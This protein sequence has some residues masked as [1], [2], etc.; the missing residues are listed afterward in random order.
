MESA[1]R[2]AVGL[3]RRVTVGT[4]VSLGGVVLANSA[5]IVVAGGLARLLSVDD[6]GAFL[7]ANS[8]TTVLAVIGR[9][10]LGQTV[11]RRIAA[12]LALQRP[13]EARSAAVRVAGLT[14]LFA[15]VIGVIVASPL[16]RWGARELVDTP[17]LAGATL[18][19]ALW[20]VVDTVRLNL[21]EIE[22]GYGRMVAATIA[23]QA[24]RY[25]LMAA[26]V[27]VLLASRDHLTLRSACWAMAG[28]G[29][30]VL[31]WVTVDA[32]RALGRRSLDTN[33]PTRGI[34]RDGSLVMFWEL[35]G[36]L[37]TQIDV[38]VVSATLGGVAIARYGAA[39]RVAVLLALP[40][41]AI[42]L[43][44]PAIVAELHAVENLERLETVLRATAA[45]ATVLAGVV[46]VVIAFGGGELL[47]VVFGSSYGR[48][49][50]VLLVLALG[51]LGNV[52]CGSCGLVLVMTGHQRTAAR[53]AIGAIVVA[54]PL[55]IV[56]THADG[57]EGAAI[58]AAAV[59]VGYNLALVYAVRVRV[60]VRTEASFVLAWRALAEW[61]AQRA[62][63]AS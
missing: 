9:F 51:Q 57:I 39:A 54:V 5:G 27:G 28:S 59:N 58:A 2:E 47:R 48:G 16:G 35:G 8:A 44:L 30:A 55:V 40:L 20:L 50:V 45:A 25:V 52:V 6:F 42:N 43:A 11:V 7:V 13:G 4:S 46:I 31:A 17:A 60:G 1:D 61:R 14:A 62:S 24:G 41:A 22:R 15:V 36:L 10:G 3:G 38:F 37:L 12:A 56:G 32:G 34:V 23:S 18:A 21:A 26:T 53:I 49:N 19:V 29:F 63:R 33:V